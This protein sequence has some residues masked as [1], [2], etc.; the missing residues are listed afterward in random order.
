MVFF[1]G[2]IHGPNK[3]AHAVAANV[4]N[5]NNTGNGDFKVIGYLP[6]GSYTLHTESS[7]DVNGVNY[8]SENTTGFI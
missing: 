5:K 3:I 4:K 8:S 6:S 7:L 1:S 2:A